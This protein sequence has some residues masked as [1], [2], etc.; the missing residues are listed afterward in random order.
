MSIVVAL[1]NNTYK[2]TVQGQ[3]FRRQCCTSSMGNF[4]PAIDC[5]LKE[6]CLIHC[7]LPWNTLLL[8]II[9]QWF[10][11]NLHPTHTQKHTR[12]HTHFEAFSLPINPSIMHIC[13]VDTL[14]LYF[15]P[16]LCWPLS[17]YTFLPSSLQSFFSTSGFGSGIWRIIPPRHIFILPRP[18]TNFTIQLH[19]LTLICFAGSIFF[20]SHFL[21]FAV[22]LF[23]C[24]LHRLL[25]CSWSMPWSPPLM[26][27]TSGYI[28]AMSS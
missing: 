27:W 15:L 26:T 1:I 16:S 9:H 12:T 11:P 22:C 21:S 24:P 2:P 8:I 10:P 25:A 14:D 19:N 3:G 23:V 28:Y 4:Q 13:S 7:L 17:C 18:D 6:N 5:L 20:A